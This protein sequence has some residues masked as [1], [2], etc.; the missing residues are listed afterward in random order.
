MHLASCLNPKKIV[1]PYTGQLQYVPCGHCQKCAA[2]AQLHWV[3]RLRLESRCWKYTMFGT[4]TYNDDCIPKMHYDG[5]T[6]TFLDTKRC[7]PDLG[8]Y[9]YYKSDGCKTNFDE[10]YL[11]DCL[12]TRHG[13][14]NVLNVYDVQL[15]FKRL[16]KLIKK[17]YGETI[18]I[19]YCGEYGKENLRPHYHFLCWFNSESVYK[20]FNRLVA[21][22]WKYGFVNTSKEESGCAK[23]VSKYVGKSGRVPTFLRFSRNTPFTNGSKNPPVGTLII[24]DEEVRRIFFDADPRFYYLSPS[25]GF[26]EKSELWRTYQ[27]RL[28]PV[29]SRFSVLPNYLLVS[30]YKVP[31]QY[32]TFEEFVEAYNKGSFSSRTNE[33]ISKICSHG[34]KLNVLYRYYLIGNFIA[35]QSQVFGVSIDFYINQI[36]KFYENFKSLTLKDWYSYL[37]DYSKEHGI[38]SFVSSDL[39]FYNHL[40][41]V[42]RCLLKPYEIAYLESYGVD[43][44]KFYALDP[45]ERSRYR[46]QFSFDTSL[47]YIWLSVSMDKYERDINRTKDKNESNGLIL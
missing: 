32:E 41:D 42:D 44:D 39:L 45:D 1:N 25:T 23:Y 47:D 29:I 9:M 33:Y 16:R 46:G 26:F 37:E 35:R 38:S 4:L 8:G 18:R 3:E 6:F 31:T 11:R 28:F 43:L 7:N 20:S 13:D 30:L 22:C 17:E 14:I 10:A 2:N 40:C 21:T 15:F 19:Y 12:E 27:V 34:A 5:Y 36:F 24:P